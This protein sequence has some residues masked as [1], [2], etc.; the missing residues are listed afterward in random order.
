MNAHETTSPAS[1]NGG[2]AAD[3]TGRS[4]LI[5]A[6]WRGE[7]PLWEAFWWYAMVFGTLLNLLTTIIFFF[8]V[9]AGAP[10][11]LALAE[12]ALPI[13]YNI[14]MVVA[15]WRSAERYEGRPVWTQLAK[16][17]ILIWSVVASIT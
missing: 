12:F 10:Y 15:V 4:S 3:M 7:K 2:P 16:A 17:K 6:L 8:M 13:P 5:G 9:S 11:W 1:A 14:F